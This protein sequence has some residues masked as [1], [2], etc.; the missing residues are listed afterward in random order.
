MTN[1]TVQ[2]I[3]NTSDTFEYVIGR[4]RL[5]IINVTDSDVT[6]TAT[7]LKRILLENAGIVTLEGLEVH[8]MD[9]SIEGKSET[10]S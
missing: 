7:D 5:D 6:T 8:D 9:L 4:Y 2:F 3:V 1:F 10:I